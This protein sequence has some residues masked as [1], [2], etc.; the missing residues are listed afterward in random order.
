MPAPPKTATRVMRARSPNDRNARRADP[1]TAT[2]QTTHERNARRVGAP[3]GRKAAARPRPQ[4][5]SRRAA[6]AGSQE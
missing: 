2:P 3:A 5:A 4:R 1:P 6:A